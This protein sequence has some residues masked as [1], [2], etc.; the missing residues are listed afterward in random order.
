MKK[1]EVIDLHVEVDGKEIVK[2]V[3][4]TF[5][6]GKVHVLMGPNGSGKSTL[7]H[8]I[9]GHPK[10]KITKG[11][12]LL[13]GNDITHHKPNLRA[14][15]GLFLSFQYP[16][17]IAGVTVSTF[18]RT[19]VNNL[20]EKKYSIIE[21][22]T[23]LKEKMQELGMDPALSRRYLNDGFSGGEKKRTE[24]LQLMMLQ[25][26]YAILDEP[27]SGTDVD[28]LKALAEGINTVR[29]KSDT[30]IVLITHYN[31]ILEHVKPDQVSVL[32]NGLVVESGDMHVAE[33]IEHQGY[34]KY[35]NGEEQRSPEEKN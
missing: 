19:T 15:A 22:H 14:R 25:P 23:L 33:E 6:L 28:A 16:V 34:K 11:K 3:T 24:I 4:L 35:L 1:L 9:M 12:I 31:R 5:D 10:Y 8:A 21:F 20:R 32:I 29:K 2:G 18:I 27:D 7:A 26:R 13:D 30:G 17:E